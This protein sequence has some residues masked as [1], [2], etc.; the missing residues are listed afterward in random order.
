MA[1][2]STDQVWLQRQIKYCETLLD[3]CKELVAGQANKRLEDHLLKM[4]R[5]LNNMLTKAALI[6]CKNIYKQYKEEKYPI[7]F[8]VSL[9]E[10]EDD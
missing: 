9:E 10:L 6:E 2:D 5:L 3:E 8:D 7:F 1:I 4:R